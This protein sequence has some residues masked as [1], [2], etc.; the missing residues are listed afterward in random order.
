MRAIFYANILNENR[1]K[2]KSMPENMADAWWWWCSC[3]MIQPNSKWITDDECNMHGLSDGDSDAKE[4]LFT[5]FEHI[6]LPMAVLA[7]VACT[8]AP[9]A[10]PATIYREWNEVYEREW[11]KIYT[12]ESNQRE[13]QQCT[14]RIFHEEKR[15][16]NYCTWLQFSAYY[17]WL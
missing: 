10:R 11:E 17:T 14:N 5:L 16:N 4:L 2:S 12:E 7:H 15:Q 1:E 3:E 8:S 6:W 9:R 13:Q